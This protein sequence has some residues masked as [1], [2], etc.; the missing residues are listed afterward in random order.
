MPAT[1]LG[2]RHHSPACARLV[3]R[4]IAELRP[5]H[6][7]IEGPADLGGRL[8]EL[9]LGHDLPIA[10][11]SH[12][13]DPVRSATSWTPL[14]DYSPEWI[15][16]TEGRA[17]GAQVHFIDLPA[18][19]P[20]F[21]ER[22]NRYADAEARYEE[23]TARLCARFGVDCVDALWD[24]MVESG[25]P[26][27][28]AGPD[29]AE[30]L[31]VY[32]DLVRGDAEADAGDR[33]REAYMA[34]W[35]RA[36]VADAGERNV[37]VVT[38]GFH[39]PALLALT[40]DGTPHAGEGGKGGEGGEGG[41]PEVPQPPAGALAG[42]YLVPYSFRQL[43]AFA[44]YQSGMPSPGYHQRLWEEGPQAA[45]EALVRDITRRL[46]A[47]GRPVSTPALI[48]ARTGAQALAALRGHPQPTRLDLLDGLAGALV[49]EA[50]DEPLP[51]TRRGQ[52]R[53]GSHPVVV[54]MV[55]AGCGDRV[56]RLH[57][58]TPVPP[59]VHDVGTRLAALGLDGTGPVTLRLTDAADLE[60]SRLLH[61]LRILGIPG[62]HRAAGPEHG[63]DP[64]LTERWELRP[65]PGREAALIE[66]GSFGASLEDAAAAALGERTRA[67]GG[68]PAALSAVLFDAVVCGATALSGP[69]LTALAADVERAGE[70]GPLGEALHTALGLWRHDRIYGVARDP[71]LAAFIDAAVGRVLW[72]AEGVHGTSGAEPARL[73]ALAAVRDA[74]LHAGHLLSL[75]RQAAVEVARRISADPAAPADLRGAGFGLCRSLGADTDDTGEAGEAGDAGTAA[76]A[77]RAAADPAAL[78]DWLAGLF[79]LAR[80]ELTGPGGQAGSGALIEVLDRLVTAMPETDFLGGL[81]A[82]R[83][84]FAYF[85]PR[86]REQIAREL[87]E[88]RGLRGSARSLLRTTADPLLLARARHLEDTVGTLLD[89]YGLEAAR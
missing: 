22:T 62:H 66:A 34:R 23:T 38:G 82:L 86:E 37:L 8:D 67:A 1:F 15:A 11:F 35:V 13:R 14:C 58:D 61:R 19:H 63:A 4:T 40:A 7:L 28:G 42:S 75:S 53:P 57:P 70:L 47:R 20:A 27:T 79:V 74:L 69:L 56:G 76:A 68:E 43:D 51:W 10:V 31:A 78:G 45:G 17:A 83:Q 30:R 39:R 48:A 77:A 89:R 71:L 88:R 64:V 54:E 72:L 5:A 49:D 9:L 24:R 6:V 73:R 33:A 55:A 41:W 44:G 59:L 25:G 16:L 80:E 85:P 65:D 50:L 3:S 2:V 29:L 26:D 46:R 18:W 60:R 81:P 21:A 87:I 52:L 12:Y 36:A 84:A 32:F